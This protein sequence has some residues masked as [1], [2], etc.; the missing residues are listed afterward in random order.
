VNLE[1][2]P[3]GFILR[4]IKSEKEK[5]ICSPVADQHQGGGPR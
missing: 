5:N 4:R 2:M 1:P 3:I